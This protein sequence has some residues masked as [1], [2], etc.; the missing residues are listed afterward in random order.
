M[1]SQ[2]R[3]MKQY[4]TYAAETA[5]LNSLSINHLKRSN[6]S[7]TDFFSPTSGHSAHDMIKPRH[8]IHFIASTSE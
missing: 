6:C 8:S 2:H 3:C 5:L 1:I 7:D 4:T